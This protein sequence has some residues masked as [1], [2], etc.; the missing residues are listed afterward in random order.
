MS[1]LQKNILANFIGRGWSLLMGL[2]FV[3]LYLRFIGIEAYGL[4]GFFAVLQ[5]S[6]YLFDFGLKA[7]MNREMSSCSALPERTD[8]ARDLARTLE[9]IYWSFGI[10]SA[11]VVYWS[12][13]WIATNWVKT[14]KLPIDAVR[15]AVALMG[16]CIAFQW[17]VSLYSGGLMGLERQVLLNGIVATLDTVRGLGAVLAIWLIAPTITIFFAWQVFISIVQASVMSLS[18]WYVIPSGTR[19]A[20]I[21]VQSL[22]KV[23]RFTAGMGA[24]GLVTFLLSQLDKV[25]LSRILPLSMFGFYNL[26]NQL[27]GATKMAA[28]SFLAAF[29]PRMTSL[30]AKEDGKALRILYHKGCQFVSFAVLPASAVITLFSYEIIYTWSQNEQVARMASPIA[31]LLVLGSAFNSMMG[32]PYV[33]TVARGW[34]MFGFYQ[35][36]IAAIVMVPLMLV[37]ATILGGVGAAIAWMV[38]NIG[39]MLISMPII[40]RRILPGELRSWYLVDVGRPFVLS[41][42]IVGLG[43]WFVPKD[44][45]LWV[46]LLMLIILW[47]SAQTICAFT[48][49]HVRQHALQMMPLY[50]RERLT[51]LPFSR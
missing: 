35:N 6:L 27:N 19:A 12:A 11:V 45:T 18:F 32:I 8:E 43:R 47:V 28:G 33:M 46:Q 4:V 37:L 7:T 36:L 14:E 34:A 42:G 3:P 41:F 40:T 21:D 15:Q 29:L 22:R 26:A 1:I 24:S 38:L 31:T 2:L 10:L 13:P 30:F 49:P 39:Y 16:V 50:L 9:I 17:P 23:W 20:N 25:I 48:L 51:S 44:E 5:T